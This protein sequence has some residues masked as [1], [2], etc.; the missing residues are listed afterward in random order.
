MNDDLK[1]VT[2]LSDYIRV[3]RGFLL[4]AM[5]IAAFWGIVTGWILHRYL[6]H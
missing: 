1:K 5:F 3:Q 2:A 6:G 4:Y